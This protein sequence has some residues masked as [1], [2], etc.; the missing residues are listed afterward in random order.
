MPKRNLLLLTYSFPPLGGIGVQRALSLAKYLPQHGFNVHVVTSKN[1]AAVVHDPKLATHIPPGVRVDRVLT[2]DLPFHARKLL[3]NFVGKPGRAASGRKPTWK[4]LVTA[5]LKNLL[6]PDPQRFWAPRA[7]KRAT[8]IVRE[9][10]IDTVLVTAP[11]FSIFLA[12]NELKRRFPHLTLVTDFRDEWLTYYFNTLGLV[13]QNTY[14]RR[15]ASEIESSA[16]ELSDYVVAVTS[17]A[18][19]EIRARYPQQPAS[20]FQ[21]IPNGF[22]PD[23]FAAFHSRPRSDGKT[24]ISYTGT[25]YKPS[26]PQPLVQALASLPDALRQKL[27]VRIIGHIESPQDRIL[28]ESQQP[29]IKLEGFLPQNQA[30]E[31]IEET[32]YLLLIWHD[33]I[34]IP[35]KLFE[36]LA[37]GKPV[38][39]LSPARSEV[40][41]LLEQTRGGWWADINNPMQIRHLLETACHSLS[42]SFNPDRAGIRRYERPQLA[43]Q[44]AQILRANDIPLAEAV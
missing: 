23:V 20:K 17:R 5:P 7:L 32:D 27:E 11:P 3:K 44:Y 6:C 35:G 21:L 13:N 1:A 15:R 39:A 12:A 19:D 41:R 34:N 30:L 33:E 4:S 28:L 36:Y 24:V 14:A 22:D 10:N 8:E 25:I 42:A 26:Q 31:R 2:P 9:R 18:L 43:A 29:V 38:L 37:T 40:R 16:V